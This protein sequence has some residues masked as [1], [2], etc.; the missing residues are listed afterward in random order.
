MPFS[1]IYQRPSVDQ[2][3]LV[4]PLEDHRILQMLRNHS[5]NRTK[6]H[7]DIKIDD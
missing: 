6:V 7:F 1:F 2:P 4:R 5:Y 3:T